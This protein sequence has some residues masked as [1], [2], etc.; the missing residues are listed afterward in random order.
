MNTQKSWSLQRQSDHPEFS[1][2]QKQSLRLASITPSFGITEFDSVTNAFSLLR[3]EIFDFC[4]FQ[5]LA[6]GILP[7]DSAISLL[8]EGSRPWTSRSS[9]DRESA[10]I[11]NSH[12]PQSNGDHSRASKFLSVSDVEEEHLRIMDRI[13]P[14]HA[15]REVNALASCRLVGSIMLKRVLLQHSYPKDGYRPPSRAGD[16]SASRASS[17]ASSASRR[18]CLPTRTAE[19]SYRVL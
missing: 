9:V 14:Q 3:F 10:V 7:Y 15:N 6:E 12:R 16:T 18:P 5:A 1:S 17:S 4:I 19:V 11:R 8:L 13:L 2:G